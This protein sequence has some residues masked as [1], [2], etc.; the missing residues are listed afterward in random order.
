MCACTLSVDTSLLLS[1]SV[2]LTVC[3]GSPLKWPVVCSVAVKPTCLVQ[4]MTE[5][6]TRSSGIADKPPDA[7]ARRIPKHCIPSD[8]ISGG[9]FS[10][11][12]VHLVWENYRTAGLQSGEGRMMIDSVVWAQYNVTNTDSHVAIANAVPTQY[13]SA[14]RNR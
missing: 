1:I 4:I 14:G 8:A 5:K 11:Y 6:F 13:A 10:S 9:T 7:C 3:K 2:Q 12:R